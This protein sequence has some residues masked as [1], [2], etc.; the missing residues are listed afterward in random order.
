MLKQALWHTGSVVK[1]LDMGLAYQLVQID[2]AGLIP[3]E[4]NGMVSSSFLMVSGETFPCSFSLST[5]VISLSLHIPTNSRKYVPYTLRHQLHD[6][7]DLGNANCL[8][9]GIQLKTVQRRQQE[10]C[11]TYR[12][13]IGEIIWNSHAVTILYNKNSYR[14]LRCGLPL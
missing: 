4:N 6:G 10:S 5:S 2:T 12:I 1:V 14:N 9:N 11:H 3:H 7:D 8:G 13:H